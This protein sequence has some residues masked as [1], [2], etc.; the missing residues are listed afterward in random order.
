MQQDVLSTITII[1]IYERLTGNRVGSAGTHGR[2]ILVRCPHR[3]HEDVHPSCSLQPDKNFYK[4]FSCKAKGGVFQ[5]VIDAGKAKNNAEAAEWIRT[6]EH[7]PWRET[8]SMPRRIRGV[9]R[10][11]RDEALAAT[12]RY[13]DLEGEL[14]YEVQRREGFDDDDIW[15]KRFLQRRPYRNTWI[16]H[17]GRT[18]DKR[19][20]PDCPCHWPKSADAKVS[21]PLVPYRWPEI[22]KATIGHNTVFLVEGEK[23]A[24]AL[25]RLGLNATTHSGGVNAPFTNAWREYLRGVGNLI[26]IPDC[27]AVGREAARNHYLLVRDVVRRPIYTDI[28][29]ER[30]DGYDVHDWVSEQMR[31]GFAKDDVVEMLRQMVND[32]WKNRPQPAPEHPPAAVS[33]AA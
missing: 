12:Y 3:D 19:K 27:D 20:H 4:C 24:D 32:A 9:N 1:E 26:V 29:P 28:A 8:M 31:K 13:V 7:A 22:H 25:V 18:C 14:L 15:S 5:M 10:P 33:P 16:W 17:L 2:S 6:G 30:E 11:F 21:V 23:C